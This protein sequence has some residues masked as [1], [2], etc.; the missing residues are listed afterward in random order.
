MKKLLILSGILTI[1]FVWAYAIR[2]REIHLQSRAMLSKTRAV[3]PSKALSTPA[4]G[5]PRAPADM[6]GRDART[7]SKIQKPV[8]RIQPHF[9]PPPATLPASSSRTTKASNLPLYRAQARSSLLG[10]WR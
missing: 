3:S 7:E 10:K 5:D 8:T 1:A 6:P 4:S 2:I 9:S